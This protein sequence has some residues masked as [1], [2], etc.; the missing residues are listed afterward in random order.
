MRALMLGWEYPPHLTG[1]LGIACE[2]IARGLVENGVDVTVVLPR[3]TGIPQDGRVSI[4][5]C[6]SVP[7]EVV[8]VDSALAPY[9]T[10][11]SYL[12]RI[13]DLAAGRVDPEAASDTCF[14]FLGGYGQGLT[15]EVERYAYAVER[16][17]ADR[18]LD[19]VYA[20]DWMT[21]PAALRLARAKAK[22]LVCHV[23]AIEADRAGA[24][25]DHGIEAIEQ[26]ALTQADRV[27]CVSRYTAERVSA[28]Y[29]ID[30]RRIRVAHNG[31]DLPE[32]A[33][34][35]RPDAPEEPTVL[36]VGRLT[37]QKGLDTFLRIAARVARQ[38]PRAR[39]VVVGDGGLA[40]RAK[41]RARGLGIGGITRFAGF[42]QGE[43][44]EREWR[45]ATVYLMP[46][47][48]DPFG[49]TALEAS[50]RDLPVLVSDRVGA[51]EVLSCPTIDFSDIDAWTNQTVELLD[52]PDLR[53][54]RVAETRAQL[55]G[56][57][58]AA[59]GRAI[60]DAFSGLSPAS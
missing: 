53:A 43:A 4:V 21:W 25:A 52:D 16:I 59:C 35:R 54:A 30:S 28:R 20:H 19:I 40:E 48:S 36:F 26:L 1:G 6:N 41:E 14:S 18:E 9:Q 29:G 56:L 12:E 8:A 58:W 51:A 5:G 44:L 23:H 57:S 7:A 55:P 10:H 37:H 13:R 38:R 3:A 27:V 33:A 42:L 47:V 34:S 32:I 49:L 39:F 45:E 11:G 22:P 2:G 31:V 15:Q 17:A 60:R 50:A 46:S 24:A